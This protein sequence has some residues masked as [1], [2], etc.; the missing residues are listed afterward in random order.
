MTSIIIFLMGSVAISIGSKFKI[1]AIVLFQNAV[2]EAIGL[3][4]LAFGNAFTAT[5]EL[6]N[7]IMKHL[8]A[9]TFLIS[10]IS[11]GVK[12]VVFK[13]AFREDIVA[14]SFPVLLV[15]H[16]QSGLLD[17]ENGMCFRPFTL[18]FVRIET[19]QILDAVITPVNE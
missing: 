11:P 13:G 18:F 10:K 16:E 1:D 3:E 5:L 12:K 14:H 2:I 15:K 8:E 6:L 17:I 19:V 4:Y 7:A 9:Y